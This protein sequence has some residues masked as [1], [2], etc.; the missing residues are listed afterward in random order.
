M[1]I[2]ELVGLPTLMAMTS[3]RQDVVVGLLDGPVALDHPELAGA[4]IREISGVP[5][6]CA[7]A[8]GVACRHGTFVAGIL[9]ACRGASAPAICPD[10]SLLVR[11]IFA[12]TVAEGEQV[13]SAT[14]DQVAFAIRECIGA[15][16][17]VLNLSAATGAPSTRGERQ[18]HEAL[19][20]AA[21]HGV[22]VVAAA[23]NQGTLGSS[24]I[25]RHPWVIPVVGYGVDGRLMDRS[26]LGSS[27]GKRGLGAPG[28]GV[29]SL[30]P[31]G[32]PL[33][34]A[35]TSFAAAVVT[36]AVALLWSLFPRA[37]AIEVKSAVTSSPL[38]RRRSVAPPL[39]DAFRA[40]QMLL[41]TQGAQVDESRG[42]EGTPHGR[43][44][45]S[46]SGTAAWFCQR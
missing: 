44:A 13:P 3:G 19:D 41:E 25:T 15:G 5:G 4:S 33:T 20:Y 7:Q 42:V 46:A 37:S 18:L 34:S 28:Q 43:R 1:G 29:T 24:A 10:C 32:G 22:L 36:G 38:Q 12:D 2:L 30:T 11:P 9:V 21:N 23:G 45:G 26:N 6:R 39:L 35:G 8:G 17:W 27:L 16:A 31:E 14:P 40:Y